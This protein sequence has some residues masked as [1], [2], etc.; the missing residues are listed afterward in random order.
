MMSISAQ[1]LAM[2]FLKK[3]REWTGNPKDPSLL[4]MWDKAVHR[5]LK[6][7]INQEGVKVFR[8]STDR[9]TA[10]ML[11]DNTKLHEWFTMMEL[12]LPQPR[13]YDISTQDHA[14][15]AVVDGAPGVA[16]TVVAPSL[17]R[18]VAEGC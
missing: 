4:N 17:L 12:A 5:L 9:V 3:T 7:P 1:M 14:F 2:Q 11:W 18:H 13:E 10:V 6:K 8:N 16:G 15:A